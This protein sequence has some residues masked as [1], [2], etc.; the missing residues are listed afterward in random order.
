MSNAS[1]AMNRPRYKRKRYWII[2]ITTLVTL[3]CFFSIRGII[4]ELAYAMTPPVLPEYKEYK[5]EQ[6]NPTGWG[7][8]NQQWF[9]HASQ[10]T[11]TLPI[12]YE[13]ILALEEPKSNPWFIFLGQKKP[14][15]EEYILRLGFI[16][17][18]KS[19]DN[20]DKLPIGFAQTQSIYFPGID[21]K[22]TA[23]GF[24]CAACHTGQFTYEDKR[25]V[26]TGG[27]AMTDL[28]LLNQSLGAAL[29]QTALSSKLMLF[30][31]R[32]ERFAGRVLG[33]NY[34]V[35][36]RATL[37]KELAATISKLVKQNDTINVT[38]GFTRLDA[39]NRIGNTVFATGMNRNRN[40][41]PINAP[42]NY[43][44]IWT[45]SWFDWVQY[46]ASIMQPLIRNAGEAL[47][48]KAYVN[49]T[50]GFDNTT[51]DYV[52]ITAATINTEAS[53]QQRFASSIPIKNLVE[54]EDWLGGTH[55]L[56]AKQFN[57]IHAP[58]W[59]SNLPAIDQE[60]AQKGAVLYQSLCQG[61]HLPPISSEDFWSDKYWYPIS[62]QRDGR[63]IK[64][65]E[66][67]LQ[68]VVIGLDE[69]GTDPSQAKV[70]PERTVDTSGLNLATQVCTRT[71]SKLYEQENTLGYL[72]YVPLND[73]STSMFALA[74]GAFVQRTNDQWFEQNYIFSK[75]EQ[76]LYEGKRP[77]C[78]QAGLGYKA[79]P[80][81]GVWA[82]VP[83]LHNGSIATLYGL[84]S[85]QNE[86]P[87]FIELGNQAFDAKNV[88]ILQGKQINKLNQ[89][90]RI[91]HRVMADYKD[92][93]FILDTR[94]LGNFNTGHVF[95][96]KPNTRGVIGRKLSEE[97]RYQIIEYLKTLSINT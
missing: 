43:P 85:P 14:F 76:A 57:S 8:H 79:R 4:Q 24:T 44:H 93:R 61:C 45:T 15:F 22:S 50:A 74:L 84:L 6:L 40:Y 69:I 41:A 54:I 88:G 77:N 2:V 18:T 48:V 47:G 68:L 64:T 19:V 73:S 59:P 5:V 71:P 7:K 67:Y 92:G 28:G 82:T 97:E 87:T 23:L 66:K 33:S 49:S 27:P 1:S 20:P 31:G 86:R 9:N 21:R 13:W 72:S 16:K 34:N 3:Y 75:Q 80:L 26:V 58:S 17:G 36:T 11:A 25:Y 65:E 70:L 56:D 39:L 10:G 53:K 52:N 96:D 42:V 94:E 12:P 37:K 78:L 95:D 32:F 83:F 35:L 91:H 55:P 46:D 38:E 63:E 29:A 62:Y 51:E 60:K 30:N 81:N 89:N 90:T